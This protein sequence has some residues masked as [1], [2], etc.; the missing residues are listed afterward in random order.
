MTALNQNLIA[1]AERE[2]LVA[3]IDNMMLF[4]CVQIMRR[5]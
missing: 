2:G 3:A 4:R 1:I 5:T